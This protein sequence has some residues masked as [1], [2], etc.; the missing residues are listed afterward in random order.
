MYNNL[1]Q[2]DHLAPIR[3]F[4]VLPG[5]QGQLGEYGAFSLEPIRKVF[6]IVH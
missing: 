6:L 3:D 4:W 1:V 2:V 5:L